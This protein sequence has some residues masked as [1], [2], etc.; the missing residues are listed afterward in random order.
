MFHEG[1]HLPENR[2][3][4]LSHCFAAKLTKIC[5]DTISSNCHLKKCLNMKNAIYNYCMMIWLSVRFKCKIE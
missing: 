5:Q 2:R 3:V 4:G 1:H